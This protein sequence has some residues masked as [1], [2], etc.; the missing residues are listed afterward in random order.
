MKS[1]NIKP[2]FIA[3]IERSKISELDVRPTLKAGGE[4]FGE[5]MSAI[6]RTPADGALVLRAPFEPRP[7]FSVLGKQGWR[8][9]VE[10]GEGDDWMIWFFR[11]GGESPDLALLQEERPELKN[12]LRAEN[13]TWF[14]D[15][16]GLT[17]PEPIELTLAAAEKLPKGFSLVQ[18]N[19]W[20]PQLLL[21]ILIERGFQYRVDNGNGEVHVTI[22]R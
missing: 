5:I 17:P 18:I 8:H 21:P 22:R 14:V 9:W 7:L 15:V 20:V 13:S 19:E 16:R 10:H 11:E 6:S 3:A 4:P 12:R 2:V 1:E